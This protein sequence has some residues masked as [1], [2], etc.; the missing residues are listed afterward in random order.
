MTGRP[1]RQKEIA[2]NQMYG[3][4]LGTRLRTALEDDTRQNGTASPGA[5]ALAHNVPAEDDVSVVIDQLVR[6][7]GRLL[8][9]PDAPPQGGRRGY[10]SDPDGQAWEIAWNP[11]WS[12][13]ADGHVTFAI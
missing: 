7:G 4:V 11:A 8:R 10:V 6:A 1:F 12:V 9:K 3:F 13:D 5:F 2:F